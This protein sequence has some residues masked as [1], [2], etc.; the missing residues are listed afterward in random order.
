M[1]FFLESVREQ[2]IPLESQKYMLIDM[3]INSVTVYDDDP[4]FLTIKTAYNLTN[5]SGK[6]YRIPISKNGT[7]FGFDGECSTIRHKSEHNSR[8]TVV[9]I[10]TVF[11]QTRRHALP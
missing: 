9:V 4:G 1:V 7:V 11:V 5:I 3:F 10:G 2:A 6:T 8:F